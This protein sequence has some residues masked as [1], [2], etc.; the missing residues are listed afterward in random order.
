MSQYHDPH[1]HALAPSRIQMASDAWPTIKPLA[2]PGLFDIDVDLFVYA[3][4][5]LVL[6][7]EQIFEKHKLISDGNPA[8]QIERNAF[9]RLC[10]E[11]RARYRNVPYHSFRHGF[12]VVQGCTALLHL[13]GV[14]NKFTQIE[15][16]ALLL[17]ALIHDIDHP[18]LNNVFQVVSRSELA[19]RYNDTSVL[20]AYHCSSGI[21]LIEDLQVLHHAGLT[22]TDRT[23]IRQLIICFVLAT[24]M[25]THKSTMLKLDG[26]I[27]GVDWASA[28]FRQVVLTGL[29][30]CGDISTDIR[31]WETSL[32]WMNCVCDE[33]YAQGELEKQLGYPVTYD[34]RSDLAS[35]KKQIGFIEFLCLPLFERMTTLLPSFG[36]CVATL[37]DHAARFRQMAAQ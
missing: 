26:A 18:G 14:A 23:R 4:D 34:D 33:F 9:R 19:R 10:L 37:K 21:Q 15:I 32:Q 5:E 20:E 30:K 12:S 11:V 6:L 7:L 31:G 13:D 22:D 2:A 25:A 29:L 28:E 35:W 16:L 17:A 8:I 27:A 24:D 1:Q 36:G 3:D